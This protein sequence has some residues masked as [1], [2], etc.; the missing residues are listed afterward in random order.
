MRLDDALADAAAAAA[1]A[2]AELSSSP[3]REGGAGGMGG[4]FIDRV[5]NFDV[6]S[7]KQGGVYFMFDSSE[8]H[9]TI[10]GIIIP[11]PR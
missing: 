7:N 9:D 11:L 6:F 4:Q 5:R 8:Q 1:A 3:G 10:F 2:A